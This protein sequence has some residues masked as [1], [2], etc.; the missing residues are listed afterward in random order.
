MSPIPL[1][2]TLAARYDRSLRYARGKTLPPDTPQPRP[3]ACWPPENIACLARYRVWLL[4]GGTSAY[5]TD[6]IYL[7]M[8]G[9][10][11]GLALKPFDQ[12]DLETDLPPAL[13]YIHAKQLSTM[14]NKL[15]RIALARFHRFLL[16]ERGQVEVKARPYD[17]EPNTDGLPAWLVQELHNYQLLQQRN[18]RPARLQENIRRFWSG[19]LRVWRFLVDEK[20]VR[21]LREVKRQMLFDFM[22]MRLAL[23]KAVTGINA[24]VRVFHTFL[25]FLR[26]QGVAVPQALL[27]LPGLTPPERLPRFLTDDQVRLLRDDLETRVTQAQNAAHKRD[28]LL[29]RAAFYL[30]WQGG[31]RVGE[32]E[33]LRLEDLD[34]G[35]RKVMV[36][37]SKGLKDRAVYLTHTALAA[38]QAYLER[39]GPGP[40]DH[41]F[42]YRN[43][44]LCKGL[45][46]ARMK[47]AGL[48]VG[49]HVYPHRLRHTCATQLLNAGCRVTSLQKFLGHKSLQTTMGYA[50]VHDRTVADDYFAAMEVVEQRLDVSPPEEET[51]VEPMTEPERQVLLVIADQLAEPEL[52]QEL[53]LVL[54]AQIRQVLTGIGLGL[55]GEGEENDFGKRQRP[56]SRWAARPPPSSGGGIPV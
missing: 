31:L 22:D 43:Q 11:L 32:V 19:H 26:E 40:T 8:A 56:N 7:P 42:F 28:A 24:E 14:W 55:K 44:P 30:L 47:A 3:T 20:G 6:I 23:G 18:W 34:F 25:L 5:T 38:L 27:N 45:L 16:H 33:E 37:Q 54:A 13:D 49:V 53:R 21:E 52:S 50:K 39:R 9:H 36:R 15:C 12:L 4:E 51:P 48:R 10:V 17:P 41:V 35:Q 2:P 29:D 46:H 1:A